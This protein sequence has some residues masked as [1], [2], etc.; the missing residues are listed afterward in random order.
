[1]KLQLMKDQN[2]KRLIALVLLAGIF[3]CFPLAAKGSKDSD[4]KSTTDDVETVEY[5]DMLG[6]QVTLKKNIQRIVLLR[7]MDIYMLVP[8]LGEEL[9]DKLIAVGTDFAQG[10]IDGYK[11]FSEVYDLTKLVNLGSVYSDDGIS[12][13]SVMLLKPDIVIVDAHFKERA[14]VK[15]MIEVGLPVVFTDLEPDPFFS[16]QKSMKMLGAMLGVA[17]KA[18]E[19]ADYATARINAT[20]KRVDDLLATGI[21]HPVIYI[22][23]GNMDPE[24]IGM[25]DGDIKSS[26]GMVWY[27]LGADNIGIGSD[28][29]AMN[30]EKVLSA[31]PDLIVIGGKNWNQTA[32][33]MRLGFYTDAQAASDHLG[34]YVTKRPGW[35]DLK[36]IKNHRLHAIYYGY[37][38]KAYNF[39]GFEAMAKMLYPEAFADVDPEKDLKEFFE[40]YMPFSYSGVLSADWNP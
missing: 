20:L 26:W 14:S 23:Q 32:N 40:K 15:K 30:P 4:I 27:R 31:N 18:N 12:V 24:E 7:T 16:G 28:F 39:A 3:T 6:R 17:D 22:E 13:E 5:T 34:E 19:M 8:L 35:S 37:Y 10:D 11:K 33:I 9:D 21:T 25:T 38:D 36:A 1:M 2:C 29:Q